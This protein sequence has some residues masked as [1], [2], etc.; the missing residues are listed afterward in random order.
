MRR[1]RNE[2]RVLDLDLLAYGAVVS[3]PGEVP[4][5]PHP[6]LTERAFVILPLADV[7]PLWRHPVSGLLARDYAADL[8]ADL[9]AN[10]ADVASVRPI[11]ES[12]IG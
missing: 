12:P 9:A 5:L 1:E 8:A 7:A 11:D 4:I 6:R 3:A 2:A 10:S